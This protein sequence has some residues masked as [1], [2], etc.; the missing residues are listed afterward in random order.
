[1]TPV[2]DED[3]DPQ[4]KKPTKL[5]D[6]WT[7]TPDNDFAARYFDIV[8]WQRVKPTPSNVPSKACRHFYSCEAVNLFNV[9]C[10]L[11]VLQENAKTCALCS[12]LQEA[13]NHRDLRPPRVV[14]L[15]SDAA[16][17]G[18]KDGPN[19]LSLYCEPGE[20]FSN[21]YHHTY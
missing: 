12:I 5:N 1:M 14:H 8:D 10:D 4:V 21:Q 6:D 16:H 17:V 11:A 9:V 13:L 18:L 2:N 3:N 19:L 15:R 20:I 7:S